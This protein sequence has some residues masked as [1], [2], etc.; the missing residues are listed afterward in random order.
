MSYSQSQPLAES[1]IKNAWEN[2]KLSAAYIFFGPDGTGRLHMA[3]SLAKAVNCQK[4][5]F[6]PC[7]V[8]ASC[9]KIENNNYPDVHYLE[10]QDSSFIKIEQ[11]QQMQKEISL[12]PFEAKRKVFIILDAEDFTPEAANCLLKVLE[13]PPGDSLIILLASALNRLF[14]TIISRCQKIRFSC[15]P[16]H[17]AELI[18]SRDY[19]LDKDS[20]HFLAFCFE[21]KLGEALKF[22]DSNILSQKNRIIRQFVLQPDS[23]ANEVSLGDKEQLNLILMILIGCMRD[24]YLLKSGI[25]GDNLINRDIKKQLS[26]LTAAFSFTDLD[27]VLRELCESLEYARKNINPKLLIDNLQL[28]WKK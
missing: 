21:G 27:R 26:A 22:K 12:S 18:L 9:K 8:C 25:D 23:P 24:I 15:L 6:P 1:F 3:R 11:I 7:M 16:P 5:T 4:G 13:E 28:L 14:P 2:Q 17:Q 20:S 19:H 10:K